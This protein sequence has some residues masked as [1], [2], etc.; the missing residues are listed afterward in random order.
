MM[1]ISWPVTAPCADGCGTLVTRWQ[2]LDP[3]YC[4][5]CRRKWGRFM[6]ARDPE[7][8]RGAW[9]KGRDRVQERLVEGFAQF[10]DDDEA[11]PDSTDDPDAE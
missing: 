3:R 6:H 1:A 8:H 11:D 7:V 9:P 2:V 10:R 5:S 4:Q